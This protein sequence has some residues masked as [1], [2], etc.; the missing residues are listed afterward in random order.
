MTKR[1]SGGAAAA[2]GPNVKPPRSIDLLGVAMVLTAVASLVRALVLFGYRSQL[3]QWLITNNAHASA[4][5]KKANYVGDVVYKDLHSFRTGSLIQGLMTAA[6]ILVLAYMVRRT[7]VATGARWA[8]LIVLVLF[9]TPLYVM[10]SVSAGLPVPYRVATFVMGLAALATLVLLFVPTS[11]AYFRACRAATM[12]AGAQPRP[13]GF[14]SLFGP[15][16]PPASS[17]AASSAAAPTPSAGESA[18][19]DVPGRAPSR[20]KAKVRS[21]TEAIARGAELARTRAKA[22]KTRRPIG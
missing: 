11:T 4:K 9:Q 21:D 1:T 22:S 17:T 8:T 16:R 7:R 2:A 14:G 18:S 10:P 5:N 20:A 15:R 13:G 12:P 19:T 6:V 3:Y